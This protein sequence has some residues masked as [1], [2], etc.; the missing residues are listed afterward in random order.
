M[1]IRTERLIL[2]PLG[3][4]DLKTVYEYSSDAENTKYMVY[5]PSLSEQETKAFLTS[6]EQEW[7]QVSPAFY[8]FA[9]I[10]N[11]V[12]I[13]HISIYLSACGEQGKLGWIINK[14]FWNMGYTSE[15]AGAL[16]SFAKTNLNL[17]RLTAHCDAR[18]TASS[19]V[20]EKL[21][22]ALIGD[23]GIRTYLKRDETATDLTYSINLQ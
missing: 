12:Q 4:Q 16:L 21:G 13:G 9:I 23:K 5:L 6:V 2:R 1:I 19:R 10:L 20:M 22:M 11:D 3:L 18:N 8:E 17:K 14:N 7:K 15:A